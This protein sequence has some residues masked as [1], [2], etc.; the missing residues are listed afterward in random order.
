LGWDKDHIMD[1]FSDL[2]EKAL[3][4]TED[5]QIDYTDF[6]CNMV[7][8][9][10]TRM[11]NWGWSP[12]HRE[13]ILMS[14]LEKSKIHGIDVL[15]LLLLWKLEFRDL[16]WGPEERDSFLASLVVHQS[17]A[18]HFFQA[19]EALKM[20]GWSKKQTSRLLLHLVEK[21]GSFSEVCEVLPSFL[22]GL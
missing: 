2:S 1:F 9:A 7:H 10:L 13:R 8:E 3:S 11:E 14:L 18:D 19:F 6:Y 16:G 5:D 15:K 22:A 12:E 17:S 4:K 21:A 20:M